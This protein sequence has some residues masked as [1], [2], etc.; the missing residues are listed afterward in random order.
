LVAI[1]PQI[2]VARRIDGQYRNACEKRDHLKNL[3]PRFL[4]ALPKTSLLE[5]L[6]PLQQI[7]DLQ[8]FRTELT[9]RL[10]SR[11]AEIDAQTR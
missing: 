2:P 1:Q 5:S 10:H 4:N 7:L 9:A 8:P 3:E 6:E 11:V